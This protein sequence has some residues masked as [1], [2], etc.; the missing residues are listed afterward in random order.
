MSPRFNDG[1]SL[2]PAELVTAAASRL[3]RRWGN[4]ISVNELWLALYYGKK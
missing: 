1:A 4:F 2:A 3:V